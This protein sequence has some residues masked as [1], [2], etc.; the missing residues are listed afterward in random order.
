MSTPAPSAE[1]ASLPD[2]KYDPELM[3]A[4]QKAFDVVRTTVIVTRPYYSTALFSLQVVWG[5]TKTLAVDFQGRLY[6][7]PQFVTNITRPEFMG[8]VLHEINHLVRVHGTRRGS[9][10]HFLWNVAGDMEINGDLLGDGILLPKGR[11]HPAMIDMPVSQPA[12][13]YYKKLRE[14]NVKIPFPELMKA[15]G[16]EDG[17]GEDAPCMGRCGTMATGDSADGASP[18]ME[19]AAKAAGA[20]GL[21][22]FEIERVVNSTSIAVRDFIEQEKGRGTV[23]AGLARFA[24][25]RLKPQVDWRRALRR[26]I[27]KAHRMERGHDDFTFTRPSRRHPTLKPGDF[28]LPSMVRHVPNL[29]LVI[30]TSGSMSGDDLAACVAE[31]SGIIATAGEIQAIACDAQAYP[32]GSVRTAKKISLQGGGGTDM[33]V[34]INEAMKTHPKPDVIVVLTDGYTPWPVTKPG[35]PVVVGLVGKT[36]GYVPAVPSWA[37]VVH[38]TIT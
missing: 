9:R 20:A 6:M 12:E 18:E 14:S 22:P 7:S 25:L 15:A 37:K 21:K 4:A 38:I 33:T 31:A 13:A 23:P 11:L 28:I 5:G 8:C 3:K 30:D 16:D 36:F 26:G 27:S 1:L 24:E 35:K 2:Q 19:E 10:E 29:A 34:G 32:S 17:E